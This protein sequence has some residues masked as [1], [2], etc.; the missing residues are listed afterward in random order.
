MAFES[1]SSFRF[2]FELNFETKVELWIGYMVLIRFGTLCLVPR[3]I[4]HVRKLFLCCFDDSCVIFEKLAIF[5]K[6]CVLEQ[7]SGPMR[8]APLLRGVRL[9]ATEAGAS[10]RLSQSRAPHQERRGA[11]VQ[12]RAPLY[13]HVRLCCKF[14]CLQNSHVRLC[15]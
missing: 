14:S 15:T 8:R 9:I 2:L 12:R 5:C 1:S 6:F 3:V 7:L 11:S 13:M 4:M 10:L